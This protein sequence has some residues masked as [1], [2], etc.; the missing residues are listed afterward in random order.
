[1]P[2]TALST[3]SVTAN[4][5][6]NSGTALTP[7][8]AQPQGISAG[9]LPGNI[10]ATNDNVNGTV[11]VDNSANITAAAGWG[12]NA[13]NFGDGSITITDEA[14]TTVSGAQYGIQAYSQGSV[15]GNLTITI[16]SSS[17]KTTISAGSLYGLAALNAFERDPG[18]I[19]ITT[20]GTGSIRINS[21][22]T[23]IQASNQTNPTTGTSSS[24]ISIT[25]SIGATINSGFDINPGGN[26]PGGIW[27]GYA[28]GGTVQTI[29]THVAGNVIVDNSATINAASGVGIGL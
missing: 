2:G 14:G 29:N 10:Q 1:I 21:G 22:G 7:G 15:S 20:S 18:N 25:T 13:Y 4:G 6:I 16:K 9:Y 11:S 28:P 26:Q 5:T 19:S 23:G 27:A 17:T 24:Q 3:V 12:I 8:G